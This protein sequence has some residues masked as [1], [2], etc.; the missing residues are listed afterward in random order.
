MC[1]REDRREAEEAKG[2]GKERVALG[3]PVS[4]QAPDLGPRRLLTSNAGIAAGTH[5]R[6]RDPPRP[7][8]SEKA[9]VRQAALQ[10]F[11]TSPPA[12]AG[13]QRLGA[14]PR[15]YRVAERK[16]TGGGGGRRS[17]RVWG[18]SGNIC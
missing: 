17:A 18:E 2:G 6:H 7:G 16:G 15:R 3:A 5:Y 12:A 4:P 11:P 8:R 13:V 9:K 1:L 14:S 10:V